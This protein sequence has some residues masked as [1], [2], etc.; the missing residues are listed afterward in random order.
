MISTEEIKKIKEYFLNTAA[1][2]IEKSKKTAYDGTTVYMCDLSGHYPEFWHRDFAMTAECMPHLIDTKAL[3]D[4]IDYIIR[5]AR[6]E[7]GWIPDRVSLEGDPCYSAGPR[8]KPCGLP[9]LDT[10]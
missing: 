2:Y 6:S 1:E 8:G 9:N 4:G 3:V 10:V 7:D 5:G